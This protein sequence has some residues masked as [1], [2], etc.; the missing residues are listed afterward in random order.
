MIQVFQKRIGFPAA[1]EGDPW[2][3]TTLISG[4]DVQIVKTPYG[5]VP[6]APEVVQR[7]PY[8]DQAKEGAAN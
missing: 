7:L 6:E 8:D 2:K 5:L 4:E 3:P 1:Q